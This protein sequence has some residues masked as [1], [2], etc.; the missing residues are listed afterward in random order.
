MSNRMS[1]QHDNRTKPNF[2][3]QKIKLKKIFK[4]EKILKN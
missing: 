4:K 1:K 3:V 2:P